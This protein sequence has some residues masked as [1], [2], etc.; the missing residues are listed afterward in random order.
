MTRTLNTIKIENTGTKGDIELAQHASDP[1]SPSEGQIWYNSTDKGLK[2][3]DGTS[4]K[5]IGGV[6][7]SYDI[8]TLNQEN[9]EQAVQ[10]IEL[11]ASTGVTPLDFDSMVS[12][13]FYDS[14]GLLNTV[15]T[16]NTTAIYTV[17]KYEAASLGTT[18]PGPQNTGVSTGNGVVGSWVNYLGSEAYFRI[19]AVRG[20]SLSA[21]NYTVRF[22]DQANPTVLLYSKVSSLPSGDWE[23]ITTNSPIF[24]ST[25]TVLVTISTPYYAQTN[26][27]FDVTTSN[28]RVRA[29]P[30]Y[31]KT[32]AKNQN[33][34]VASFAL[35]DVVPIDPA[36]TMVEI[37]LP[38]ITGTVTDTQ[39]VLHSVGSVTYELEDASTNIDTGLAL[40]T[41]NALVNLTSNPVKMRILGSL[42]D[43][44]TV[45]TYCLKLWKS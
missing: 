16:G 35:V 43:V 20:R 7:Y 31:T 1:S 22:Y 32:L 12:D 10:I 28:V 29:D 21:T 18:I 33:S 39:A 17:D 2:L 6:D 5:S 42:V 9:A 38:A 44:M 36:A 40:N 3:Y 4:A 30:S 11:Q 27:T 13:T 23:F 15:N 45:T 25:M 41:K 24:P 8:N 19:T 37:D 34:N 14:N 26:P